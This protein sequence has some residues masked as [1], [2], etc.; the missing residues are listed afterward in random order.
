MILLVDDEPTIVRGFARILTAAGFTVEVAHDGREAAELARAKS[1]DV[2]V[3]DIAMPEMNGLQLLRSVREHDLDVPV[4]LMTGGPAVESAVQAMEYGALRYLIKPVEAKYLEE[5]VA[6]ATRLHQ[7]AKIK[8]EALELFRLE[9]KHLGDR[10]GLEVRFANAIKTLWLAFQPIVSWADKSVI[11][12]EALVRNEE[13][14]LRAPPDLFEAAERLGR[15]RELGRII[16]DRVARTLIEVPIEGEIFVNVHALELDDD[17]LFSTASPLSAVA[18]RVVLEITERAPLEKIKD[19]NGRVAQLRAMGYRIAIDDLGAGYAGL[20]SFAQLEP[21]V[22]KVDMSL[23]RGLDQSPTKQKL[24][25]SIVGL[26]RD[27]EIKMIAEG[28]ETIEERDTLV[29]LGGDL[30]QGYL[31]AR[32]GRAFPIAKF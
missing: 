6:R 14:T 7:M 15:L 29:R 23:I 30:C 20:T 32:P 8:R 31:F 5:V 27:L 24:L 19:A 1:F 9:G 16:R 11:A 21:E 28:I 17:S 25:R 26:C 22:V 4:I 12:Y 13:P 2:I 18:K 3:S 10:A